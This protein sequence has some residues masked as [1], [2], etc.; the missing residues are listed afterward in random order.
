MEMLKGIFSAVF[1]LA[2]I[3]LILYLTYVCTKMIGKNSIH[4]G[5]SRYI[6]IVDQIVLAQ[7]KSVAIVQVG[8]QYHLIGIASGQITML[9]EVDESQLIPLTTSET[10]QQPPDFKEL[11][12]KLGNKRK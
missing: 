5:K 7:D 11:L 8:E 4:R 6:K 2:V 12:L 10:T 9:S 3:I 1:T